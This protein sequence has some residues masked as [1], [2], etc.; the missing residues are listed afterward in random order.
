MLTLNDIINA[1]FRKS[2]F[3][4]Y[5]SEDV[6]AFLDLVKDSYEQLIKKNIEQKERLTAL[7]AENEELQKKIEVLAERVETYRSEEDD[8]KNAL[9]SA[10]KLGDASVREARHKAEII[11][12]DA[13]IKADRIIGTAQSQIGEYEQ[14]LEEMKRQVSD[15]RAQLMEIYRQHLTLISALPTVKQKPAPEPE[16]SQEETAEAAA[17]AEEA[18][19]APEEAPAQTEE[20]PV[21]APQEA[22]PAEEEPFT[23]DVTSFEPPAEEAL[24]TR[25]VRYEAMD[26][27]EGNAPSQNPESPIDIFDKH[28]PQ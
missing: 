14:Q 7:Q 10:Q 15:F 4:G 9:I 23:L 26:F 27:G 16:A 28:Q 20:A 2:N 13:N 21:E 8:I 1:N 5:K 25:D 6:D 11:I 12:K 3:S 17:P 19:A 24:P 22:A 18:A